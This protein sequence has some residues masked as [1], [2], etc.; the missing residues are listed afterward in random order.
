MRIMMS[1]RKKREKESKDGVRRGSVILDG[2]VCLFLATF[3][4]SVANKRMYVLYIPTA[5]SAVPRDMVR[6]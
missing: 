3:V 1:A 2:L 6:L 4:L 5:A